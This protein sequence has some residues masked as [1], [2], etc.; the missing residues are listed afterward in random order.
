MTAP[1]AAL[2]ETELTA[3]TDRAWR[4]ASRCW[5]EAR[6]AQGDVKAMLLAEAD[7]A[8]YFWTTLRDEAD[9]RE[10]EGRGIPLADDW[11]AIVDDETDGQR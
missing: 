10:A 7:S 3:M 2:S 8:E 9:N 4:E 11:R 5:Q 6:R 1:F